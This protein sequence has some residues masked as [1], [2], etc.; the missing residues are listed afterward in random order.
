MNNEQAYKPVWRPDN[1]SSRMRSGRALNISEMRERLGMAEAEP[2]APK[3]A[4]EV[5]PRQRPRIVWRRE[6]SAQQSEM[7]ME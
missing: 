7:M 5:E 2:P 6:E 3:K 4:P 1:G